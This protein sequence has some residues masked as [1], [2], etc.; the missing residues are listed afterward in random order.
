MSIDFK[1]P[2]KASSDLEF[3]INLFENRN[4]TLLIAVSLVINS[5]F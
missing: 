5:S 2:K 4:A 3:D 1:L